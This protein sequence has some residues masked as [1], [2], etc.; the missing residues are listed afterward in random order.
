MRISSLFGYLVDL[1]EL[2]RRFSF[3]LFEDPPKRIWQARRCSSHRLKQPRFGWRC[4][5]RSRCTLS[6]GRRFPR[7]FSSPL[8]SAPW[9]FLLLVGFGVLWVLEFASWS[10]GN[11]G[12]HVGNR[13]FEWCFSETPLRKT[14]DFRVPETFKMCRGGAG[15]SS[16]SQ[17]KR[18]A[19]EREHE[20]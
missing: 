17:R 18:N 13:N 5:H 15:G 11:F 14:D 9:V 10:C 16:A 20:L 1:W 6:V 12:S 2:A 7:D 4:K 19:K 8:K 3:R